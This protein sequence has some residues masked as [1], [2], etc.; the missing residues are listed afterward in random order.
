L[1]EEREGLDLLGFVQGAEVI[2]GLVQNPDN[3]SDLRYAVP[4]CWGPLHLNLGALPH[5]VRE[6]FLQDI[7]E[8]LRPQQ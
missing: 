8:Q 2:I 7:L 1:V 5:D 4:S 3:S 6:K